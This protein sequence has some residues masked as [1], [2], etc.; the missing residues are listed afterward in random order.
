MTYKMVIYYT[1]IVQFFSACLF[2]SFM[3]QCFHKTV[4]TGT[5]GYC[6]F[7]MLLRICLY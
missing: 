7:V 3:L 5:I 6:L 1:L 2:F 4:Y